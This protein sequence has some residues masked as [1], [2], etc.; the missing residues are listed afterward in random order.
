[1]MLQLVTH[2]TTNEGMLIALLKHELME[3]HDGHHREHHPAKEMTWIE[4]EP[5]IS[6]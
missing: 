4:C 6:G 5:V 3:S 2:V 1:M